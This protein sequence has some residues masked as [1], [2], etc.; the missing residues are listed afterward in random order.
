[1]KRGRQKRSSPLCLAIFAV[2]W[3]AAHPLAAAGTGAIASPSAPPMGQLVIEGEA[4]ERLSLAKTIRHEG[5]FESVEPL[6]LQQPARSVSLPAGEFLFKGVV[7]KG[8]YVCGVEYHLSAAGVLLRGQERLKIT[9]AEPCLLRIGAPLG[10]DLHA[11]RHGR[12][13]VLEYQVLDAGGAATLRQD[14]S[15]RRR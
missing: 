10:P 13:I 9:A 8:G 4:I 2:L 6:V 1:M 7:L 11:Y 3:L 12:M 5:G 15:H 14:G